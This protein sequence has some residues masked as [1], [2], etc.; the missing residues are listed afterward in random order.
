MTTPVLFLTDEAGKRA[1]VVI[2]ISHYNALHEKLAQ[3]QAQQENAGTLSEQPTPAE[4]TD[5]EIGNKRDRA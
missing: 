3:L 1:S 5:D 4:G 2:E